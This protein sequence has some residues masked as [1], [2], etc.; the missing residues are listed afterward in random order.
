[1]QIAKVIGTVVSTKKDAKFD[2]LKLLLVQAADV[3]G[4]AKGGVLCAIDA[5]GAGVGE[6][7]LLTTGSSARLTDVTEN[8]PV[9]TVVVAIVDMIETEGKI[10]YNK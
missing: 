10:R 1:M 9:D 5:V 3:E 7:V 4:A 8:R 6:V 2:G